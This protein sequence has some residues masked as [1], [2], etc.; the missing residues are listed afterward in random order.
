M[1]RNVSGRREGTRG[2]SPHCVDSVRSPRIVP[3]RHFLTP[4]KGRHGLLC[5]CLDVLR[6]SPDII[7]LRCF[8]LSGLATPRSSK[9]GHYVH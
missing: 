9:Y 7:T 5:Y 2:C 3:L 8:P 1:H 6:C 4:R